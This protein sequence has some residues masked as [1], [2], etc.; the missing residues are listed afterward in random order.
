MYQ[1]LISEVKE[2]LSA[3]NGQYSQLIDHLNELKDAIVSVC[4]VDLLEA[5]QIKRIGGNYFF[6]I[7]T[8]VNEE[9]EIIV[10]PWGFGSIGHEFPCILGVIDFADS[11]ELTAFAM[12]APHIIKEGILYI[13]NIMNNTGKRIAEL[14]SL[15]KKLNQPK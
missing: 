7:E 14:E 4:P 9:K 10:M 11:L 13:E 12:A 1:N 15:D 5:F 6:F 3:F 8:E 2:T